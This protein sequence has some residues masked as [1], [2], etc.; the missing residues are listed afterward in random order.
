MHT[1]LII[2][3]AEEYTGVIFVDSVFS[4]LESEFGNAISLRGSVRQNKPFK[5]IHTYRHSK[6]CSEAYTYTYIPKCIHH[7]CVHIKVAIVVNC[8]IFSKYS[9]RRT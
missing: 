5:S 7:S 2:N 6:M 4:N 1:L 3:Y 8:R 9:K